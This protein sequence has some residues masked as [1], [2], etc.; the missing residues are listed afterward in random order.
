[1]PVQRALMA[2]HQHGIGALVSG[3]CAAH[4]RLISFLGFLHISP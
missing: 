1:M 3:A 4:P 2:P